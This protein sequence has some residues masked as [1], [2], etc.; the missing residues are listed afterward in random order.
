MHRGDGS[1]KA[2]GRNLL[3]K[4]IVKVV[5]RDWSVDFTIDD[6]AGLG[7]V[8][9]G[10]RRY[11]SGCHE[12]FAGGAVTVN[13]GRRAL[14]PWELAR[15]REVLEEEFRLKVERFWC[16]GEGLEKAISEQAGATFAMVPQQGSASAIEEPPRPPSETPLFINST[17]RSGMKIEHN[18]DVVVLGDVNPG[19]EVTAAGDIVVLGALLGIAHAGAG[20]PEP[21]R[22]VI[23]SMSLRPLQLRIGRHVRI[24]P[25]QRKRKGEAPRPEIAY[26]RGQ[27]IVVEPF[28][29]KFGIPYAPS[30]PAGSFG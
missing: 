14:S 26:V 17:C 25:K 5:G 24:T 9:D 8:E 20:S 6:E 12:W 30:T 3:D 22:A 1:Q 15:I 16:E 4:E 18:C 21:T 11:L 19:A 2:P 28:T 10:L 27:S 29:G 13:V 23:V 7:E